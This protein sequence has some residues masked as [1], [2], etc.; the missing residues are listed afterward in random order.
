MQY[1]EAVQCVRCFPVFAGLEPAMQKL[2]AFSSEYM[3]FDPGETLFGEGDPTDGAY[4]IDAGE[5]ELLITTAA[6][7]VVLAC[8]GKNELLGETGIFCNTPRNAA[9]RAVGR[10]RVLK[11]ESEVFLQAVTSNA[12]AALAVMRVLSRK[13]MVMTERYRQIATDGRV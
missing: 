11:I 7:P 1:A 13:L 3:V 12:S 4:L 9:A 5:V 6:G 2:V 10:V 8:F